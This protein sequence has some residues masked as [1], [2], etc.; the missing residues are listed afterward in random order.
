MERNLVIFSLALTLI[1]AM[2]LFKKEV[3]L[4]F[5][6]FTFNLGFTDALERSAYDIRV[7]LSAREE[8]DP[9][10]V[11]I[12]IDEKSLLEYG[13]F[14]WPRGLVAD[15][16]NVS[17]DKYGV[18]TLGF[19]VLFA[20]PEDS[21]TRSEVAAALSDDSIGMAELEAQR[22]DQR[23]ADALEGRSVVMGVV[24]E[25][26]G[27][28]AHVEES[29]GVLPEPFFGSDP[30]LNAKLIKESAAREVQR[31]SANIPLLQNAAGRAGFFSILV[32][33]PDGIIRRVGVLNKYQDKLYGSL[34]LQLVTAYFLDEPE[35]I[36]IDNPDDGYAGLEGIQM[37]HAAIPLDG[38]AGVY[39]PYAKALQG[40]EYVSAAD[41]LSG[42]YEG[43]I[44]GAIALV[45][46]SAA[47]L[48][49]L[50]STPVAPSLP[51][52]EVHANVV[53]AMLD[54]SFR[55][56]PNF[57]T[58]A[59]ML[60]LLVV[61]IILS[62]GLPYFSAFLS[63]VLYL[64]AV[65]SAVWLNWYFWSE[66]LLILSIAPVL[67]LSTL[68]YIA[69]TVVGFFVESRAHRMSKKM[70][71]LYVPPEVV[72]EM[73]STEDVLTM[74]SQ[75]RE[76]SVLF[77]DIRGFT[78][79]S[80]G[81]QPEAL[82]AWM[83][84]FLT[85]MTKV[86]HSH[87]GAIDK[88]MG[89]AI[90][91]FWGAPLVDEEHANNGV[92]AGLGMLAAVPEMNEYFRGKDWPEV[93]IGVGLNSGEMSVGNM[94]SEF[95]MAYTVL[96]DAVNLGSR[97]EGITKNYGVPILVTE[98]TAAVATDFDYQ[99]IDSVRVKGKE[100]PVSMLRP[101][102]AKGAVPQDLSQQ[103]DAFHEALDL[104]LKQEFEQARK[105]FTELSNQFGQSVLYDLYLER[106]ALFIA[107]PPGEDWDGVYTATSK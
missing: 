34:A 87:K 92:R 24:F 50:R 10:V 78:T 42:T 107:E 17:F 37:L 38:E 2:D 62:F 53:S 35:P 9:R 80:E 13:Q 74:A 22:G 81:M 88:Y 65:V 7:R 3:D 96:G 47:G 75:K 45:G 25:N 31:Y 21:F 97:V 93:A 26:D 94:G 86:I 64:L 12:D 57:A 84:E 77:A 73:S 55:I 58:A 48:V 63:T 16:V 28:I 105:L 23:L 51:G 56:R 72:S 5:T 8:R 36:L 83:N 32:Q 89:D 60:L 66:K 44:T 27:Q 39:V 98:F 52:V 70:F 20:E 4:G 90:M 33:D 100:E 54:G 46:T 1:F 59:D 29:V 15:L 68:L 101:L 41:L 104:Y 43:D 67:L 40:Y 19:D 69:D 76:M 103:A 79:I 71:G 85:P 49:D 11:I 106:C 6:K 95:R 30:E 18:D 61:G 102:G 82:S 99:R 14:P 91:A